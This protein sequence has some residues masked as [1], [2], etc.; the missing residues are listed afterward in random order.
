MA[1]WSLQNVFPS[2]DI[3][4]VPRYPNHCFLGWGKIFPKFDGDS[5]LAITNVVNLLKYSLDIDVTHQDVLTI[6]FF[7]IFRSNK[8]RLDQA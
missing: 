8:K 2:L 6:F 1:P 3:E 7:Y 4:D 5:S